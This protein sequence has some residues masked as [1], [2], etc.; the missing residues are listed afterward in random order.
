MSAITRVE[1]PMLRANL[2]RQGTDL[3]F[4]TTGS[5]L[6]YMNFTQFR[7][8]IN[9]ETPSEDLSVNGNISVTTVKIDKFSTIS[10][11]QVN[12]NL[13]LVANGAGNVVV[14]G[15]NVISGN[16]DN[17]Q[18][19]TVT[20]D[21]AFFTRANVITKAELKLA[22]VQ[23]L[24][25]NRVVFTAA[26]NTQLEDDEGLQWFGSN[27]TLV[28]QNFSTTQ[29]ALFP[30]ITSDN[31]TVPTIANNS[32]VYMAANNQLIGTPTL[33][34][35]AGNG[36]FKL[37]GNIIMSGQT[38]NRVIY[39]NSSDQLVTSDR[40]TYDGINFSSPYPNTNTIGNLQISSQTIS[41]VAT[42]GVATQ[43]DL[44]ILS[45]NQVF[46][47]SKLLYGVTT[48]SGAQAAGDTSIVA[49]VG[50]V[51]NAITGAVFSSIEIKQGDTFIRIADDGYVVTPN[52]YIVVDSVKNS[53]FTNGFA[54]IQNIVIHD[55]RISS[56]GGELQLEGKNNN[57]VRFEGNSSIAIPSGTTAQRPPLPVKGDLRHNA[58]YNLLEYH[59]GVT[60]NSAAPSIFSQII[61]TDGVSTAYTIQRAA[62]TETILVIFNGVVQQPYTSYSVT[63]TTLTFNEVPEVTD[64]IEI[65]YLTYAITY[66]STPLFVNTPYTSF[67]TSFVQIDSWYLVQFRGVEYS[68][69]FK[70]QTNNQFATG[71]VYVMHDDIEPYL[72]VKEY[73]NGPTPYLIFNC[74]IDVTGVVRLQ[75]KGQNAGNFIKFRATYF[76]DDT[77]AYISWVSNGLL[78]T[79]TNVTRTSISYQLAANTS[80]SGVVYYTLYDGSLPP[81]VTLSSSGLLSGSTTAVLTSTTYTFRIVASAPSASNTI[82]TVLSMIVLPP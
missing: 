61:V 74:Y 44:Q 68:F 47:G 59:D 26:D 38:Q 66:A 34:Y 82:S 76:S 30:S 75:V 46:F 6:F 64:I 73:S 5:S 42:P 63:G 67:D 20:P 81:G 52:V 1:G 43:P 12:Q 48:A 77:Q 39:K 4:T 79:Y 17:T 45:Q 50:Y 36:L 54:N 69:V 65:R 60:W 10:T 80:G 35:F 53:E 19:G 25:G 31:I 56:D 27:N 14:I 28:A 55:N 18:I 41:Q 9:T 51:T 7:I 11:T 16:I 62:G 8:G 37:T 57:R 29:N 70:N 21:R 58:D 72:N 13:T 78:A 24:S 2:D 33:S 71:Q 23:N 32:I 15:A 40:L 22:N 3:T 49:T